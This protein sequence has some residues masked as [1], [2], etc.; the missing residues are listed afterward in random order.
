MCWQL[1][2][3]PYIVWALHLY[4]NR[5]GSCWKCADVLI[6]KPNTFCKSLR[7]RSKPLLNIRYLLEYFKRSALSSCWIPVLFLF[8]YMGG[9]ATCLRCAC[10]TRHEYGADTS[11]RA[12]AKL[13]IRHGTARACRAGPGFNSGNLSVVVTLNFGSSSVCSRL[14]MLPKLSDGNTWFLSRVKK[15]NPKRSLGL[16]AT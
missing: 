9:S 11:S 4:V 3:Q 5:S 2:N 10:S 15:K 1:H 14:A 16:I 12:S 13:G 7:L 6:L 8:R